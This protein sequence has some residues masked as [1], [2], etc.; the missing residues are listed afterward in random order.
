ML[1]IKA[2]ANNPDTITNPEVKLLKVI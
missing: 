1:G 2:N